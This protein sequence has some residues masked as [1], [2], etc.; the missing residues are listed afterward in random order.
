MN[1]KF[2]DEKLFNQLR[3]AAIVHVLVGSRSYRME[4]EHS[5][6]DL[7]YVYPTPKNDLKSVFRSHHQLQYKDEKGNDHLF[8]S[9]HTFIRNLVTGDNLL[10]FEALHTT[11]FKW[12]LLG[13]LAQRK[14]IFYSQT[15]VR[16]Y[17]GRARKDFKKWESPNLS[18]SVK[19]KK[20]NHLIRSYYFAAGVY[21][22]CL[23]LEG[24][25][26]RTMWHKANSVDAEKQEAYVKNAMH[27]VD[28]LRDKLNNNQQYIPVFME[29]NNQQF[30]DEVVTKVMRSE[31]YKKKQ[32]TLKDF[33]MRIFYQ[34]NEQG[35]VY[36]I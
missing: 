20:M 12:S 16:A 9:L 29:V 24:G 2:T 25:M 31:E 18:D 15:I 21:D 27:N 10:N 32:K 34:A 14:T 30:V 19:T 17:L 1:I 5:D 36:E 33:D 11:D 6:Y 7:M 22:G 13:P 4:N 26:A 23:Q 28:F 35:V 8:V 3:E